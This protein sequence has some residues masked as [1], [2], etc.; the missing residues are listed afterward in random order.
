M[1]R[2][3]IHQFVVKTWKCIPK[4]KCISESVT[5]EGSSVGKIVIFHGAPFV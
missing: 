1:L 2:V 5:Q 4:L 3:N